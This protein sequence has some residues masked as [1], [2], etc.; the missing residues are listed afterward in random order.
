MIGLLV[1]VAVGL[2]PP[3]RR[4]VPSFESEASIV[5]LDVLVTEGGRIRKGLEADDVEVR[6]NGVVQ[7]AE[8]RLAHETPLDLFLVLD[9]SRSVIGG[10]RDDLLLAAGGALSELRPP[11]RA[12]L[13]VIAN[14]PQLVV[15]PTSDRQAVATGIENTPARGSTP[16]FDAVY[17]ALRLPGR[18][19][20]R[21]L[22]LLLTDGNDNASWLREEDTL[23]AAK[24]A[25]STTY[26]VT[27][28]P[29]RERGLPTWA[30]V[31]RAVDRRFPEALAKATGGRVLETQPGRTLRETFREILA[32]ASARYVIG[33]TP[34]GAQTPGWHEVSVRLK[35]GKG[36]VTVRPGYFVQPK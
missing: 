18:E 10:R 32:E 1:A 16:L 25:K 13:L 12:A 5:R 27:P 19:D 7:K 2:Q 11:D 6:D 26:V 21:K 8:V 36:K 15:A 4:P 24:S 31:A 29:P 33:Y 28:P 14:V 17:A 34:E 22:L 23:A 20:A 3:A 9:A 30:S 35:S